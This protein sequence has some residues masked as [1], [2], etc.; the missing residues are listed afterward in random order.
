MNLK[1]YGLSYVNNRILFYF[2]KRIFN[3][4]VFSINFSIYLS[5]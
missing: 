4:T 5:Q 1:K 2:K 3:F